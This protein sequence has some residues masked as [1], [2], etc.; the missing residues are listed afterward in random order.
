MPPTNI[1]ASPCTRV[2]GLPGSNQRGPTRPWMRSRAPRSVGSGDAR[3]QRLPEPVLQPIADH[4]A[5]ETYEGYVRSQ[6]V[7]GEERSLSRAASL[8][9]SVASVTT[10]PCSPRVARYCPTTLAPC[11]AR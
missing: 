5:V 11:S 3:E 1:D 10:Y 9:V 2:I 6:I 7:C 4:H 8:I